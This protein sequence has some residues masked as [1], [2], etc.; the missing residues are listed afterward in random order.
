MNCSRGDPVS[1]LVPF[2]PPPSVSLRPSPRP[3]VRSGRD[4]FSVGSLQSTCP[5]PRSRPHLGGLWLT[6]WVELGPLHPPFPRPTQGFRSGPGRSE[7]PCSHETYCA[8]TGTV[9]LPSV[10]L[11]CEGIVQGL[12]CVSSVL[13]RN[14]TR[15]VLVVR[16]T[17]DPGQIHR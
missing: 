17:P 8:E 6:R 16:E 10:V 12:V 11:K 7:D 13:T 5:H 9:P 3:S 14:Q 15:K 4:P 2:T 1:Y